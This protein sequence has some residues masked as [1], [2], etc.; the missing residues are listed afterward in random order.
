MSEH[1]AWSTHNG[2]F[3]NDLL[4]LPYTRDTLARV[5]EHVDEVQT[6]LRRSIL[7]ENPATYVCFADSALEGTEFL[8]ELARRTGCGLLLDVDN[9]MVSATNHGMSPQA[10]VDA[11]PGEKVEEIHLA[12]FSEEH[13]TGQAP[14]LIDDHGSAVHADVWSLYERALSRC[15]VVPSLIEWDNRIPEWPVLLEEAQRAEAMLRDRIDATHSTSEYPCSVRG[16]NCRP[17]SLARSLIRSR[18]AAER[19]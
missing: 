4:P 14:L 9:V 13:C 1:L 5:C 3:L 19:Y 2:M 17:L 7:I 8:T 18:A 11:F 16:L 10:Y 6:A 15:G 12:G